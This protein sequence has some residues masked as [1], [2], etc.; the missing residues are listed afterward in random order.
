MSKDIEIEIKLP[1]LN[2][3]EVR[4]FLNSHAKLISENVYQKDSYCVP[5]HR[6]FLAVQYPFE[7]LRLRLS[8][9]GS[10][11]TYK[12]YYPPNSEK[13]D[14]CDE[15]ETKVDN[16][17]SMEKILKSIDIREMVV[18]EKKRTTWTLDDVE[19]VIDEVTGLGT[20][21]ELEAKRDFQDPQSGKRYLY[22]VLERLGAHVGDEDYRGYPYR[23]MA[24]KK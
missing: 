6:D 18:V 8:P 5:Q 24:H 13:T 4:L 7:W 10:F 15:F 2:P 17:A 9:Q 1:L 21:M 3:S 16:L 20:F 19:I 22:K 23:I 12:H 11:I 14:Y